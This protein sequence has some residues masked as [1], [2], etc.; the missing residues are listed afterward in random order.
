MKKG[1]LLIL[2]ILGILMLIAG[3]FIFSNNKEENV[4]T[5]LNLSQL[6]DCGMIQNP[7]CFSNRFSAC[8]PVTGELTATDGSKIDLTILGYVNETC[9]L[10]REVN[11]VTNLNC[12]FPNGTNLTWD[13]IDQTFGN[14]KGMQS[15]VDSSCA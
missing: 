15:I 8:L 10:Q 14:D 12:Y 2:I 6:V 13:L 5:N 4:E 7:A 11:D 1:V 9:H 3:F